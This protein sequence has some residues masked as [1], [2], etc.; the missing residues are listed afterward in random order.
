[1]AEEGDFNINTLNGP[2]KAAILLLTLGEEYTTKIFEKMSENEISEVAFEM[3]KV[4][5][6]PPD[7]LNAVCAEFVGL[8]EGESKMIVEG[9][10]FIRNIVNSTM[11]EKEAMAVLDDLEK[12][13]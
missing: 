11:G 1:M 6:I 12:K 5:Q 7:M 4:D 3:S 2:Q 8:F 10:S 9:D 13:R